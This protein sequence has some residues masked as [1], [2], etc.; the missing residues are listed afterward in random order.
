VKLYN[1]FTMT[2]EE[3]RICV[4][5]GDK[6]ENRHVEDKG[7]GYQCRD[8]QHCYVQMKRNQK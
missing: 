3:E 7:V 1:P 5:C 4:L 8:N 2:Y 6:R